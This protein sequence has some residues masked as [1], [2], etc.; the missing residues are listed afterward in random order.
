MIL[1]LSTN[2]EKNMKHGLGRGLDA[3]FSIYQDEEENAVEKQA[4]IEKVME[5]KQVEE[6]S[7]D[8]VVELDMKLIDP[9]KDQPRKK[10]DAASLREL[11]ESI[12]Q[13]GVIQPIIVTKSSD[14]RYTIVA[15]ERRF[16]ACLNAGLKVIPAIIKD[17]SKQQMQEIALIEN[18]QREDL[19][20]IE[21]GKAIRQ[22]MDN[23]GFTQEAVAD[24]I[25]KS[26]PLVANTLRLL[27]LTPE[28][29]SF[30]E[31]GQLSAGHGKCLVVITDPAKQIDLAKFAIENKLSVRDF[32]KLVKDAQNVKI[33]EPK[34]KIIQSIE[35]KELG[36]RIQR[37]FRTKVVIHGDD[38]KGKISIDYFTSD[39]LDRICSFI[40]KLER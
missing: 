26:R 29:I 16:R 4:A 7:R 2:K 8:G 1:E 35:L 12:K 15:G 5:K 32:E 21:A 39:D 37:L 9:N 3:L 19:N 36:H 28:V 17:F 6:V 18:L 30:I 20:P 10:F 22:L 23:Y 38:N 11:S 33:A 25:G 34:K 31:N 27:S 24:R 14:N 13:H 40:S